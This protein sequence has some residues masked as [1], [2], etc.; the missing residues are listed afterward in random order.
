[1]KIYSTIV[2]VF[3]IFL[4]ISQAEDCSASHFD[5]IGSYTLGK[6]DELNKTFTYIQEKIVSLPDVSFNASATTTYTIFNT[7]PTFFYRDS[8]QKAEVLGNDTII[9]YGGRL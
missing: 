2:I 3:F 4:Q 5:F 6:Q 9:I 8:T 1:M 7:K